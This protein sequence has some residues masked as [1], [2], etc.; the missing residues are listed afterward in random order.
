MPKFEWDEN[1]NK[2]N[3]KKHG[4]SFEKAKETFDDPN[5]IVSMRNTDSEIRFVRVGKTAGRVLLSVIYTFRSA[6]VRIISARSP[7]KNEIKDY[8]EN[9]LAQNTDENEKS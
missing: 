5:A 2:A 7:R 6:I 9:S 1:K 8:L 4:V 3:H